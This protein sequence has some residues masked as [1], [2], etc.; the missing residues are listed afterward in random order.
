MVISVSVEVKNTGKVDGKEVVQLY[1][2]KSD[3]KVTRAAQEL[4]GFKKVF[5]K[6]GSSETVTIQIPVKELA[7]YDVA[8][9]KWT[10]EPGKYTL[11]IGNSSRDLKFKLDLTIK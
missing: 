5:V 2:A 8:A 11:N 7:Y 6:A 1:A 10:V 3:S 4:K 9:K